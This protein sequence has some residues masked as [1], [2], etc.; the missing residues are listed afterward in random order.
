MTSPPLIVESD[1]QT[2][3]IIPTGIVHFAPLA[4]TRTMPSEFHELI[5]LLM[6]WTEP[7]AN[8]TLTPPGWKLIEENGGMLAGSQPSEL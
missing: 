8:A 7:S 4:V 1:C 2:P 6:K 5:E 3:G